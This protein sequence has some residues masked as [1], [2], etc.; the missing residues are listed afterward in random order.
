MKA[1]I[2][3]ATGQDGSYLSQYLLNL[4]YE[5]WGLMRGQ[6]NPKR[7]WLRSLAPGIQIVQGDLLDELSLHNAVCSLMPDEVYNFGAISSPGLA[8]EQPTL[9]AEVTG[10]G[11]LRLFEAVRK[12]SPKTRVLQASSIAN[13][14][15]YGAAKLF[16]QTVAEDFRARGLHVSCAVFGGHHSPRR[17]RSFF[18]RK[19]TAA[20]ADI[21]AGVADGLVLGSLRRMQDW[22]RAPDFVAQLPRLLSLEPGDYVMSTGEPHSAQEWVAEAFAVKDLD[23]QDWVTHDPSFGNVTDV[24]ALTADPDPRLSWTPDRDF[25][26]LIRWMVE[27]SSDR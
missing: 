14:G 15:P 26:G 13:H 17:G 24:P 8:W 6:D 10:L 20:V 3:G 2:T 12:C 23:W 4:G 16:A 22:G 21:S 11:A 18:A 1:L 25:K 27:E 7:E 5:V 9:T 19:V